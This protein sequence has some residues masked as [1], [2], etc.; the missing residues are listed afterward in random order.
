MRGVIRRQRLPLGIALAVV[1]LPLVAGG[2][3][4]RLLG[5]TA[6]YKGLGDRG[7]LDVWLHNTTVAV[8]T[9][10]VGLLTLGLLA[11]AAAFGAWFVNG[12]ALGAY[13]SSGHD[14]TDLLVRLPHLLPELAAFVLV[15]AVGLSGG[16]RALSAVRERPLP[17]RRTWIRDS[18]V[19]TAAGLLLLAPASA[20]EALEAVTP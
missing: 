10:F 9:A 15:T 5:D 2:L 4:G 8:A 17:P 1:T 3:C 7:A 14:M 12:Y 16:A 13:L 11:L 20:L 19:L 18:G 6:S